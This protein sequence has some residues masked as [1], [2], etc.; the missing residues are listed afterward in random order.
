MS[1]QEVNG[2]ICHDW[3]DHDTNRCDIKKS[4]LDDLVFK[5]FGTKEGMI[6]FPPPILIDGETS[7]LTTY[8]SMVASLLLVMP[9]TAVDLIPVLKKLQMLETFGVI[10]ALTS[11]QVQ[12][13][14]SIII[15]KFLF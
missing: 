7:S 2:R 4:V 11:L 3:F 8:L 9:A 13:L 10:F 15:L 1:Y 14:E 12:T 5:Y 6:D